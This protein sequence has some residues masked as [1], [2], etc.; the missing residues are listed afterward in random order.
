MK[1]AKKL[2]QIKLPF[3][4]SDECREVFRSLEAKELNRVHVWISENNLTKEVND[5]AN[6][7]LIEIR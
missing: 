7:V 4:N 3:K 5:I 6:Q 1:K 2:N